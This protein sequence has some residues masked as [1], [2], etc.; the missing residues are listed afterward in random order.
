[1]AELFRLPRHPRPMTGNGIPIA[2]S[3]WGMDQRWKKR[4]SIVM[5][6]QKG[7]FISWKI[8]LQN[9]WFRDTPILGNLHMFWE[10][11]IFIFLDHG[12]SEIT[13]TAIIKSPILRSVKPSIYCTL[14]PKS[15]SSSSKCQPS[16]K[17]QPSSSLPLARP[18]NFC[19]LHPQWLQCRNL[20]I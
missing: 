8:P 17:C 14:A 15:R 3:T 18:R 11:L 1:M 4:L 20:V 19:K 9:G 7:W 2:S 6:S 13:L 5:V 10:K 16:R 12:V